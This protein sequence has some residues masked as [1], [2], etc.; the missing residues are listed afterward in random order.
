MFAFPAG[1]ARTSARGGVC[2]TGMA[3]G[4]LHVGKAQERARVVRTER[5]HDPATGAGYPWRV[6]STAMVNQYYLSVRL[7]RRFRPPVLEFRFQ[8]I[9]TADRY[10]PTPHLPDVPV[11]IMNSETLYMHVKVRPSRDGPTELESPSTLRGTLTRGCQR[12][13]GYAKATRGDTRR[14][15]GAWPRESTWTGSSSSAAGDGR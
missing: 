11:C 9:D 14:H 4:V 2:A 6:P 10:Q 7:R 15:C 5:R 1:S 8:S 13:T 3:E 12:D